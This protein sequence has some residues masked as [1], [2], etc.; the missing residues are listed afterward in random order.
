M[1]FYVTVILIISIIITGSIEHVTIPLF[2][3]MYPST[4]FVLLMTSIEG[5][6]VFGIAFATTLKIND[7][8]SNF[9]PDNLLLLIGT[10]ISNAIM[11]LCLLYAANPARTPVLIQSVFL[12][13]AI[14]P[15]IIFTK[16]ILDKNVNYI[17]HWILISI[18]FLSASIMCATIPTI[19]NGNFN[20]GNVAWIFVYICG[21]I[22]LSL[23][24]ILQEKYTI[25]TCN[26]FENKIKLAF[27]SGFFQVITVT[28]LCWIDLYFG[29]SDNANDAF[30]NFTSSGIIFF[31]DLP[32]FFMIQLFVFDCLALFL[33][34][35][36]LNTI[37]TNYNMIL[38]NLTNQSVALFF[39]IFPQFNNGIHVSP[40]FVIISLLFN[41]IAVVLWIRGENYIY[42][43]IK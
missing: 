18:I 27:Y 33:L 37:S 10:G 14:F 34:S 11:S 13:L 35:I 6:F 25:L 32:K 17:W 41:I 40:V 1:S 7:N 5:L 16:Y 9:K 26:T 8:F 3:T 43:E 20:N 23:T 12:G 21:I 30:K 24:N 2:S 29:Y 36:Y 42:T 39:T 38:T 31:T 4:Y 22:L 19:Q 28:S 15:S